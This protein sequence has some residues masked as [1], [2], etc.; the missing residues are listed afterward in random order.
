M[1]AVQAAVRCYSVLELAGLWG[2]GKTFIYDEINAGR[3][4]TI[5]FGR[6]DRNK[7]RIAESDAAAWLDRHRSL[8]PT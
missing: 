4:P 5:Q 8:V 6:G 7:I 1:T 2:C 3:L